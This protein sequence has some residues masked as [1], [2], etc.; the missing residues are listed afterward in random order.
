MTSNLNSLDDDD[1]EYFVWNGGIFPWMC[2][3]QITDSL[4]SNASFDKN[5]RKIDIIDF[6]QY[7]DKA[8]T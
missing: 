5:D 2:R 6:Q 3:F 8:T 1:D 4:L 7:L